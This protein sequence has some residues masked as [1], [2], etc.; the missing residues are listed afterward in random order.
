MYYCTVCTHTCHKANI[1][2]GGK[3]IHAGCGVTPTPIHHLPISQLGLVD[4]SC[5]DDVRITLLL[6]VSFSWQM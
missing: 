3:A 5:K 6:S 1:R 2:G 4:I